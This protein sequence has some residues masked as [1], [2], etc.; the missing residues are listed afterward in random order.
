MDDKPKQR[1]IY[2]TLKIKKI[3]LA[4][5]EPLVSK[6]YYHNKYYC[7]CGFYKWLVSW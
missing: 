6:E 3:R 5:R 2:G 1:K 7:A 4:T